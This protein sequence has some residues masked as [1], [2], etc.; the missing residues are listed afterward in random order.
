LQGLRWEFGVFKKIA[1]SIFEVAP[2]RTAFSCTYSARMDVLCYQF[3]HIADFEIP[4]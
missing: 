2:E 4:L 3:L 1:P